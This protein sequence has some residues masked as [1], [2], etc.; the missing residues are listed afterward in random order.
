LPGMREVMLKTNLKGKYNNNLDSEYDEDEVVE[1]QPYEK[2]EEKDVG[3]DINSDSDADTEND[4]DEGVEKQPDDA[5][6]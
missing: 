6:G 2:P 3:G 1:K 5:P 4:E